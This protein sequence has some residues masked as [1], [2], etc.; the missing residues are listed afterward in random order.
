MIKRLDP[1]K[2]I[3]CICEFS[4]TSPKNVNVFHLAKMCEAFANLG[5][6]VEFWVREKTEIASVDISGYFNLKKLFPIK[7]IKI[8]NFAKRIFPSKI[9]LCL[10]YVL[11]FFW[12]PCA[13]IDKKKIIYTMDIF[14]AWIFA[15][16]GYRAYLELH[17]LLK[18]KELLYRIILRKI[19]K[20]ISIS[21][22]IKANL[23]ELGFP[24]EK[25]L[26][27]GSAADIE[28]FKTS[29][30]KIEAK[31]T[32][33]LP[34]DKIL[35]GYVGMLSNMGEEKGVEEIL[36]AMIFL[37]EN[38]YLIL[39]GG[40]KQEVDHYRSLCADLKINHRIEFVGYKERKYLP[41]YLKAFDLALAIYPGGHYDK[42]LSPLKIFE[43][44][45]TGVPIVASDIPAVRKIL[46]K[47]N[48]WLVEPNN[49]EQLATMIKQ[50]TSDSNRQKKA[51]QAKSDARWHSWAR[52]AE[53]IESFIVKV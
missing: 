46:N 18:N 4:I 10:G 21:S 24:E 30:S 47:E 35:L 3:A 19:Q 36:K 44:M 11:M 41:L 9:S 8:W 50:V 28:E 5:H 25:I 12:L 45:A 31:K 48:S 2:S 43:Y 13:G 34:E 32:L 49:P 53:T 17:H 26:C 51:E 29:V 52:R 33:R 15:F 39:I 6:E 38:Y 22:L 40:Y 37:E 23:V 27:A 42:S 14:I 7:K 1:K 20:I 16:Y